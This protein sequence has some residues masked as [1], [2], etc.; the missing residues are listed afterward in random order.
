MT[1]HNTID[2]YLA[3]SGVSTVGHSFRDGLHKIDRTAALSSNWVK[4]YDLPSQWRLLRLVEGHQLPLGF[5]KH[6]VN[7]LDGIV[8]RTDVTAR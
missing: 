8:T 4:N 3:W 1:A 2:S 6:L 5:Q 7:E